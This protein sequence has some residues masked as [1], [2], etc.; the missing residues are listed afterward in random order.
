MK[1][2]CHKS[3]AEQENI[4]KAVKDLLTEYYLKTQGIYKDLGTCNTPISHFEAP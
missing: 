2:Y 4:R 3:E 1:Y